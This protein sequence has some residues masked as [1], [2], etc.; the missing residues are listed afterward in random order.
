MFFRSI[1]VPFSLIFVLSGLVSCTAEKK[2]TKVTSEAIFGG[3]G[4]GSTSSKKKEEL[5]AKSE[6]EKE[7]SELVEKR[8]QEKEAAAKRKARE[9]AKLAKAEAR[10]M[11]DEERAARLASEEV[12][13]L[14]S[15]RRGAGS[16]FSRIAVGTPSKFKSEGHDVMV[17]QMH[18]AGLNPENAKIEIDLSE[19]KARVFKN[20]GSHKV[21]VIETQVSTGKSGH[22]TSVGTYK[23]S[24]KLI[25]KQSTLYGSWVSTSGATVQSSGDVNARPAGGAK[26][27]GAEM[28]YWLRINGGI[29]MHVGYVPDYPASHG[30]IRVP[31][32]VQPLIFAK[33]GVGTTVSITL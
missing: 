15:S 26:F 22:A 18:L 3:R 32:A 28:P 24:E 6:K 31:S 30:C 13:A 27:V 21:L 7:A 19:Q 4:D 2:T 10:R 1:I 12:E 8:E 33:V 17:N 23:I 5:L 11:A 9:E 16:F 29:G 25:T 20:E 14:A